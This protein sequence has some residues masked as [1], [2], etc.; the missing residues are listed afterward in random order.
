[1]SNNTD[2]SI[3]IDPRADSVQLVLSRK[4][5]EE[6]IHK[7]LDGE[8][9]D[10]KIEFRGFSLDRNDIAGIQKK[11][12]QRVKSQNMLVDS[13]SLFTIKF[14]NGLKLQRRDLNIFLSENLN[15]K[16]E[17]C[18][19]EMKMVFFIGF[20]RPDM[21]ESTDRVSLEKQTVFIKFITN[22]TAGVKNSFVEYGV[23]STDFSW[24]DDIMAL[25]SREIEELNNLYPALTKNEKILSS[26]YRKISDNIRTI[27]PMMLLF[28]MTSYSSI[29]IYNEYSKP[30]LAPY[31]PYNFKY[32]ILSNLEKLEY[33]E[34]S[35]E[36]IK[37]ADDISK[38]SDE[39][40]IGNMIHMLEMADKAAEPIKYISPNEKLVK[41]LKISGPLFII[42]VGF[43]MLC[44]V[45]NIKEKNLKKA[46]IFAIS[47]N[48]KLE[49]PIDFNRIDFFSV[50]LIPLMISMCFG[51]SSYFGY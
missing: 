13:R 43:L 42:L 49:H 28:V 10:K 30:D 17:I 1:M 14:V 12:Y 22:E 4:S 37:S 21:N 23:E 5:I 48:E 18:E 16:G 26:L 6:T 33:R 51:F 20:N 9:L 24:P 31:T 19:I 11:L 40:H 2:L 27:M 36:D 45:K 46:K 25:I 15:G 38:L 29:V 8:R 7:L 44:A 50:I 34:L 32:Q 35:L 47:R 41:F 3:T 39:S